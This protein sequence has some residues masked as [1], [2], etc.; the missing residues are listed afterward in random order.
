MSAFP[1]PELAARRL[2]GDVFARPSPL[3]ALYIPGVW[4]SVGQA[5]RIAARLDECDR[6]RE[7]LLDTQDRAN[8]ALEPSTVAQSKG[9]P[10][11]C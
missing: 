8:A 4:L 9:E 5:R 2:G 11:A 6:Y 7:A 1:T 3:S 10:N